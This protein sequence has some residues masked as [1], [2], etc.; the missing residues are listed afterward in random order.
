MRQTEITFIEVV[1]RGSRGGH[2][3][4]EAEIGAQQELHRIGYRGMGDGDALFGRDVMEEHRC[5]HPLAVQIVLDGCG[6]V[7]L[8]AVDGHRGILE[9]VVLVFAVS[10]DGRMLQGYNL[11]VAHDVEVGVFGVDQGVGHLHHIHL[12]GMN[13]ILVHVVVGVGAK[14]LQGVM[15]RQE[16]HELGGDHRRG[17]EQMHAVVLHVPLRLLQGAVELVEREVEVAFGVQVFELHF[18]PGEVHMGAVVLREESLGGAVLVVEHEIGGVSHERAGVKV[19]ILRLETGQSERQDAVAQEA[20]VGKHG[21][22]PEISTVVQA[23]RLVVG[24]GEELGNRQIPLQV[25]R[26]AG[27]FGEPGSREALPHSEGLHRRRH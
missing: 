18:F 4:L 23:D 22:A 21:L 19:E 24:R 27:G 1:G 14:E 12:V 25:K 6:F 26:S 8:T 2:F 10:L 5:R 11:C 15:L 9:T 7:V 17:A 13:H 3:S 20:L 16:R